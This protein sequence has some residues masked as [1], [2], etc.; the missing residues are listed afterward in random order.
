MDC[1]YFVTYLPYSDIIDRIY[2]LTGETKEYYKV[3]DARARSCAFLVRKSNFYGRGSDIKFYPMSEEEVVR[4]L[5]RQKAV[6][7]LRKI[8]FDKL[9][10]SQL[11][12][13]IKI[14]E[15]K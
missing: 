6:N 8:D 7:K 15:E 2:V 4:K 13:I 1:K 3:E 10:D 9:T 14:V 5:Q 11:E 12:R